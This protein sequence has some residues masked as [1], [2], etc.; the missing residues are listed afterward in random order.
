[1]GV[2]ILLDCTK[3]YELCVPCIHKPRPGHPAPK[4][5]VGWGQGAARALGRGSTW[6]PGGVLISRGE[7]QRPRKAWAL[8]RGGWG[9][10]ALCKRPPAT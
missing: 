4:E 2:A 7:Q 1:M 10:S 5:L 6:G 3:E 9:A 8:R